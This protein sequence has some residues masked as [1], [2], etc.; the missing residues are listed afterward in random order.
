MTH[1]APVTTELVLAALDQVNDPELHQ[2][3]TRLGMVENIR[4]C[5]AN[6]AFDL[7]L[8]TSACPLKAKIQEDAKAAV[9]AIPGV[10]Q[11]EVSISGKTLAAKVP[12]R[13][14]LPGIKN[15]IA[16]SSG[17]GGVGKTTVSVNLACA[18]QQRGARVGILDA[19]IYGPNVPLM[20]GLRQ[21]KIKE[22]TE[23]GKLVLPVGH[24]VKV[25][26]TAFFIQED[27][28]V[29]WRG[30]MLDKMIR[31]FMTR[32]DWGE[33]DYLVIDLP[34]GTG[35]AQLTIVQAAPL[36]GAIIVTTP[37]EVAILD[38][39]KGL[40]MFANAQI[41]VFGIVE[42]MSHYINQHGEREELFGT[43]GG[44]RAAE[45]LGVPLLA[46]VPLVPRVRANADEG[47]PIV[48]GD[49]H[50]PAAQAL[51]QVADQVI[52]QICAQGVA[53]RGEQPESTN[54]QPVAV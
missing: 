23:D 44:K 37:Q 40:K 22:Q 47:T 21:A 48:V 32:M 39:R 52:A 16:V 2:S 30:P 10:A 5:E 31:D 33:L 1:P 50:N 41:P 12:G 15:I 13:E 54:P 36:S 3:L 7:V 20:M 4:I 38:S 8:T 35:D 28:P 43:G 11:V 25:V 42:N 51:M 14:P 6:V 26:S 19:D 29:V 45:E 24:Q 53:Q 9:Q 46:E 27:Q 34:P 18:L 49:P 17:K